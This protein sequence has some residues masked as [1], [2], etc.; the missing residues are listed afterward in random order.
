[1]CGVNLRG[2]CGLRGLC[3]CVRARARW[4]QRV[5]YRYKVLGRVIEKTQV[6]WNVPWW[7]RINNTQLDFKVGDFVTI[8]HHPHNVMLSIFKPGTTPPI[9]WCSSRLRRSRQAHPQTN[10]GVL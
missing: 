7:D 5:T 6:N 4:S 1:M 10:L 2:R 8:Y 9:F 3:V